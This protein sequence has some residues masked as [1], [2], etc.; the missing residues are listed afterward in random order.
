[1]YTVITTD[2][3]RRTDQNRPQDEIQSI[4]VVENHYRTNA[5]NTH[6]K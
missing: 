1:M 2:K 6:G 5:Q 3:S 4:H